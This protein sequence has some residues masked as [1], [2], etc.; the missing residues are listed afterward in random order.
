MDLKAGRKVGDLAPRVTDLY[1]RRFGSGV[2]ARARSLLNDKEEA[3]EVTQET[4]LAFVEKYEW[5]KESEVFSLLQ[6]I[7]SN[8]AISRLRERERRSKQLVPAL[9][10][11]AVQKDVDEHEVRRVESALELARLTRGE[12]PQSLTVALLHF[13]EGCT[14]TE[15][16][17]AL[18]LSRKT[19]R[20]L[21]D[22]FVERARKR[23]TR[24]GG[25]SS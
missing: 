23:S 12:S 19:V 16:G 13:V 2:Y 20:R 3:W 24:F 7:A 17:D 10:V 22:R 1:Y 6:V 25:Q 15:V 14:V 4:F 11:D 9:T 21:L 8:K 5:V 18:D